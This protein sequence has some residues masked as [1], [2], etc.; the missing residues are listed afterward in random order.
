MEK[1]IHPLATM[2]KLFEVT[3][4]VSAELAAYIGV[5][6]GSL[7]GRF[8][9]T[10]LELQAT[11]ATDPTLATLP[12]WGK[13]DPEL[14]DSMIRCLPSPV[15]GAT[16]R[17]TELGRDKADELVGMLKTYKARLKGQR[18]AKNKKVCICS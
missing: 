4:G 16:D 5:S 15:R 10:R 9:E 6:E 3:S 14:W 8:R 2:K 11:V 17:R 7:A 1:P 13:L 18:R 12:A